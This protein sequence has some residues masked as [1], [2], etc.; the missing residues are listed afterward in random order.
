MTNKAQ[1]NGKRVS[2]IIPTYRDDAA[3]QGLLRQLQGLDV[4]EIIIIDGEGRRSLPPVFERAAHIIWSCAPR[5]R[6]PQIAH[7]LSRARGDYLWVLHA[8]AVVHPRSLFEIHHVLKVSSTALGMFRLSFNHPRRAYRL[9]EWFA[10]LDMPLS[11]FGD[12]G[13]F[14][15]KDALMQLPS[16]LGQLTAAPILE[17]VILRKGLK[18]LGR[19]KKSRHKIGTS[20]RRFERHGLWRMQFINAVILFKAR[21]GTP[22]DV[23]YRNY[24]RPPATSIVSHLENEMSGSPEL[25]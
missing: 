10:R 6:G 20:P 25:S 12:Q 21:L 17:D 3:L 16:L 22:A 5:G 1:H 18:S 15:R 7:G 24:Y 4:F 13:F 8:D 2:V 19:V 9:F 11:S 14:F 23:L